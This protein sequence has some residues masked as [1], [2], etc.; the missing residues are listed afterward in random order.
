[1]EKILK[2]TVV[3]LLLVFVSCGKNTKKETLKQ[4]TAPMAIDSLN[5]D[6][7]LNQEIALKHP[8]E[9]DN[10]LIY[11]VQV[12]AFKKRNSSLEKKEEITVVEGE[13]LIK[14]RLGQFETYK[15]AK[16]FKNN[17]LTSF[18]DAFIVPINKGSQID[19]KEALKLSNEIQ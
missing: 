4:P 17:I 5:T 3:F 7:S 6:E 2:I 14:Y 12:G 11:T 15:D 19:I 16:N 8:S 9:Y 18:P 13:S 10:V 1:M